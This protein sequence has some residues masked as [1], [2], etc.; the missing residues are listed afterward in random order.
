MS[1]KKI[2]RAFYLEF[3]ETVVY[4]PKRDYLVEDSYVAK[5]TLK[6]ACKG[7]DLVKNHF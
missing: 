7:S 6:V 2:L 1:G 4:F 3:K 5:N